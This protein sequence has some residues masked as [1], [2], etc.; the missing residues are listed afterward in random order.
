[1]IIIFTSKRYKIANEYTTKDSTKQQQQQ[2]NIQKAI[3]DD[4]DFL[5]VVNEIINPFLDYIVIV[6]VVY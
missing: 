3:R 4:N 1:M 5:V 2:S 6:L